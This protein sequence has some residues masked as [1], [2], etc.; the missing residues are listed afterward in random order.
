M[1]KNWFL[2]TAAVIITLGAAYYQRLTGPSYPKKKIAVID[3]K[4]Y[5]LVFLR[6]ADN[7]KD[8]SIEFSVPESVT[9]V[10]YYKRVLMDEPYTAVPMNRKDKLSGYLPKQPAAGKLQYYVILTQNGKT[11][12]SNEKGPVGIRFKGP[13]PSAILIPH[14][15]L[16]FLAMFFSNLTGLLAFAGKRSFRIYGLITFFILL[17][18]G[19]LL[20]PV[21]Q[22]YAFGE[23]W[24]GVPFGWDLTD[25]KTLIAFIFWT[26]AVIAN[27]KRERPWATIIAA[28]VML[29]IFCIPHSMFGSQLDYRTGTIGQG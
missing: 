3:G 22:K 28:L 2:W 6:S 12:Y 17:V 8:V 1:K 27:R 14:V 19:M 29:F 18:G 10:L 26:I 9:G 11:V 25:N 21:V 20:G 5:P 24:T 7:D 13:V 16:I 23:Y 15:I 4:E